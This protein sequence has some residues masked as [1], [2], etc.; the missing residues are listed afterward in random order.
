MNS[1]ESPAVAV[2]TPSHA[3]LHQV[4]ARELYSLAEILRRTG[5]QKRLRDVTIT[6]P[7]D[8]TAVAAIYLACQALAGGEFSAATSEFEELLDRVAADA[9][10]TDRFL[11]A[12]RSIARRAAS[13]DRR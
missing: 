1:V 13:S 9:A 11:P 3:Q 10:A 12:V 5:A 4:W 6:H 2:A 8:C 7:I